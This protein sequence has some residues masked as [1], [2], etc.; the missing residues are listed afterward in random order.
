MHEILRDQRPHSVRVVGDRMN[1]AFALSLASAL[2]WPHKWLGRALLVGFR[3]TGVMEQTGVLRQ[4]EERVAQAE[5]AE[6]VA[7]IRR[8]NREWLSKVH[9]RKA[10]N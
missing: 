8:E 3:I 7:E 6:R 4:V 1:V 2:Q 9:R 5:F 10:W